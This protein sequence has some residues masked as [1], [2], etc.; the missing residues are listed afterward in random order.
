MRVLLV[1]DDQMLSEGLREV[2]TSH[3]YELDHLPA[4]ESAVTAVS[5]THYDLLVVDLGLPGMDG[6]ELIRRIRLGKEHTPILILTARDALDDKV[7]G[8]QGGADD[9]LVKPFAVPELM[10][11]VQALIRRSLSAAQ[12]TIEMG[13]LMM[14]TATHEAALNGAPLHLT[15]REWNVLEALLLAAPKVLT[16]AR[17]TDQLGQW[18]KE[19][20]NNAVE[21]YVSR[22][23]VKL[24]DSDVSIRTVRGIGYR[25][26]AARDPV[27]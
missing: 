23:R 17:L 22:L 15:G 21:I 8:L 10:A 18:D 20:T 2:F 4:A 27:Q 13:G 7:R 14:N 19:I 5:L 9:Y 12:A 3:G 25:L 24:A 1:E 26:E 16:K 6:L 11:R